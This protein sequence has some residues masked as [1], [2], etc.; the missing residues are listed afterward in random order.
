LSYINGY[1][2][3]G[4]EGYRMETESGKDEVI[5]DAHGVWLLKREADAM[6]ETGGDAEAII[7]YFGAPPRFARM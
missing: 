2:R 3:D 7:W 5:F 1:F 4:G 6:W